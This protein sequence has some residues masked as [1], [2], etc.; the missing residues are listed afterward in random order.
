M[1]VYEWRDAMEERSRQ[2]M[3]KRLAPPRRLDETERRLQVLE[4]LKE[5]G[6]ITEEEYLER[7]GA[8]AAV[9]VPARRV[10]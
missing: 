5:W 9:R 7:K 4:T 6:A 8:L 3:V 1:S 10:W 2:K